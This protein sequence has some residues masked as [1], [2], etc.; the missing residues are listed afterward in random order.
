MFRGIKGVIWLLIW[1][2]MT[3]I[4]L[5]VY[6]MLSGASSVFHIFD[7]GMIIGLVLGGGSVLL[8]QWMDDL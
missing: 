1:T 4:A 7:I 8:Y 2:V 5:M 6:N 3:S